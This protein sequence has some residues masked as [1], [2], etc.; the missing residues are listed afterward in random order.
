MFLFLSILFLIYN[1]LFD[2]SE[3]T[4]FILKFSSALCTVCFFGISG[5]CLFGAPLFQVTGF[6]HMSRDLQVSIHIQNWGQADIESPVAGLTTTVWLGTD[7]LFP[8]VSQ[9]SVSGG[10]S[11]GAVHFLWDSSTPWPK[12][13]DLAATF[14]KGAESKGIRRASPFHMQTLSTQ[15][16][17][18]H[19][20]LTPSAGPAVPRSRIPLVPKEAALPWWRQQAGEWGGNWEVVNCSYVC[21]LS[22]FSHVQL[23]GTPWTIAPSRPLCPWNSPDKNTG[24]G[25]HALLQGIFPT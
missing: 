18:P 17:V 9:K 16:S 10:P 2:L 15:F 23:C 8:W 11:F 4:I 22:L 12:G 5:L 14:M 3:I 21:M 6:P 25:C 1:N 20:G 7:W 19:L 24:V 13:K